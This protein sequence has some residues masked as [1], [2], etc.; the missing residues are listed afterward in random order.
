MRLLLAYFT[1]LSLALSGAAQA[2]TGAFQ[3]SA[4]QAAAAQPTTAQST[5]TA[6]PVLD[7][8]TYQTVNPVTYFKTATGL[9]V[10]L[11]PASLAGTGSLKGHTEGLT[12]EI[13]DSFIQ[14]LFF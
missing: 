10:V 8:V 13:P 14:Q 2:Q 4:T 3:S 11:S 9:L 6:T 7:G 12:L 1:A 5:V